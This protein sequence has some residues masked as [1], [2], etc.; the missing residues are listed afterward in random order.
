MHIHALL[1][2]PPPRVPVT[3]SLGQ[4][5]ACIPTTNW[6]DRRTEAPQELVWSNFSCSGGQGGQQLSVTLDIVCKVTTCSLWLPIPFSGMGT[7]VWEAG[8]GILAQSKGRVLDLRAGETDPDSLTTGT[9]SNPFSRRML[10]VCS[11]VTVGST[12]SGA[13][14]L[15]S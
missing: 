9:W 13:D 11:Q 1:C 10:M 2:V 3:Y 7:K 5:W 15:S 12:V 8:P 6:G 4:G 14:R